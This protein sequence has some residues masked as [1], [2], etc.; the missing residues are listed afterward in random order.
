MSNEEFIRRMEQ[1][2]ALYKRLME[3]HGLGVDLHEEKAVL[4][5]LRLENAWLA[6]SSS[7]GI[8]G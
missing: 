1:I 5:P 4:T 2:D 6:R 3:L 7:T 8:S